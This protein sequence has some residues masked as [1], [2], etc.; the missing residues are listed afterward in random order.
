MLFNRQRRVRVTLAIKP[1]IPG[2]LSRL[3]PVENLGAVAATRRAR[4]FT[5]DRAR[6]TR[7]Y[8]IPRCRLA[9]G[10]PRQATASHGESV[11]AVSP[12]PTPLK[13]C[14]SI[15]TV[16]CCLNACASPNSTS[17]QSHSA[18]YRANQ[19]H[20]CSADFLAKSVISL[21]ADGGSAQVG[22]AR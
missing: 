1:S 13:R 20:Q 8:S 21:V 5:T 18:L 19:N 7:P 16:S 15:G 22:L 14:C 2:V 12:N 10:K 6:R 17:P 3:C 4:Q 9:H 11:C